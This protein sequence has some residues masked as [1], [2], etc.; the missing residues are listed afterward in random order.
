MY[1]LEYKNGTTDT[2]NTRNDLI[3]W[4]NIIGGHGVQDIRKVREH[5][6]SISVLEEFKHY[7]R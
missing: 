7:I 5:G 6:I 1:L 4:L 2:V 3:E